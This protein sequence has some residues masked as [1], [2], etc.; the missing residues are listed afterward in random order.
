M[1]RRIF[2][3]SSLDELI[4]HFAFAERGEIDGLDGRFP[5]YN[6]YPREAYPI[7][8]R[9]GA[10]KPGSLASTYAMA[11][12]DFTP[13]W[14][15]PSQRRPLVNVPC[16]GIAANARF[17][18][19]YQARRCLVP[20]SGFFEWDTLETGRKTQPYAVAMKDRLPFALAG[21]SAIW[22]HPA[23]IDILN[24]AILTCAPNEMMAT[25]H[26][27]MPV[28]LHRKDYD[29]WLS[30]ELDPADLMK[31]FPAALMNRWPVARRLHN[32]KRG[33]PETIT[34]IALD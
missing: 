6:G 28:I 33:G 22:R 10:Q 20:V 2:V 18:P 7:I 5:R 3:N 9:D 25:I 17:G 11:V 14:M 24:F 13:S 4:H 16:E 26:D 27:R 32:D 23:G 34:V 15:K 29:R 30:S 1:C 8:I 31:P 12:W 19:A 21:I